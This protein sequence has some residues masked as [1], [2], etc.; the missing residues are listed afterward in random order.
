[1]S[2]TPAAAST[3][4]QERTLRDVLSQ[5][6]RTL[7][8]AFGLTFLIDLLGLTPMLYMMSA[9]DR[10]LTSRS[11]VTLVSLTLWCWGFTCFGRHWSGYGLALWCVCHC[12]LTGS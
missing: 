3:D 7:G 9:Y 4:D 5:C 11:G 2:V 1:M 8:V 12:G 6:R 10:V